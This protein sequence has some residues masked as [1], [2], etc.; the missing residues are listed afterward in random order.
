M[1]GSSSKL[2][3]ML[4]GSRCKDGSD[5]SASGKDCRKTSWMAE[6]PKVLSRNWRLQLFTGTMLQAPRAE[7]HHPL[8]IFHHFVLGPLVV[9][10]SQVAPHH[11]PKQADGRTLHQH[12]DHLTQ[13]VGH[14][15]E[16][17]WSLT[18]LGRY[19]RLV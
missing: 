11:V 8:W 2:V 15:I 14:S 4:S 3:R 17:F 10:Q 19:T 5:C 16:A 13:H 9:A 18:Y 7:T 12:I 1:A 6:E